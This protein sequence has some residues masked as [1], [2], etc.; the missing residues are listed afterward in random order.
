M[1]SK[2]IVVAGLAMILP[3]VA[4]SVAEAKINCRG[5]YQIV[6]GSPLATPYCEDHHLAD[7][8][9]QHGSRV[10]AAAIRDDV[11]AKRSACDVTS[12][13][14]RTTATCESAGDSF[15]D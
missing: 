11:G 14:N 12:G 5:D 4:G 13:D 10:S 1:M 8:A 9:R 6:D 7:V 3:L 2:N 15:E